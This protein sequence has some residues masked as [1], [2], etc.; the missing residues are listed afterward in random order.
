M[1]RFNVNQPTDLNSIEGALSAYSTPE[2]AVADFDANAPG[3]R[4]YLASQ[5]QRLTGDAFADPFADMAKSESSDMIKAAMG[6]ASVA[7]GSNT[8]MRLL[9][10]MTPPPVAVAPTAPG[11]TPGPALPLAL[12]NL[13]ASGNRDVARD[14]LL[15]MMQ[16]KGNQE[17]LASADMQIPAA[18]ASNYMDVLKQRA[19]LAGVSNDFSRINP[20]L[21]QSQEGGDPRFARLQGKD[22]KAIGATIHPVAYDPHFQELTR[23]DP[24]KA[25][26]LYHAVTNR[27]YGTD[28][29]AQVQLLV[30]QRDA[31]K[32]IIEDIKSLEADP[33][34][35]D[36]YKM[37]NVK[38]FDGTIKQQRVPVT[39]LDRAAIEA[40]GG[41][42]RIYGVD[43]PG[44]GGLK[45][46]PGMTNDE[47][48]EYR[49][50]TQQLM[51]EKGLT[52]DAASR[53]AHKMMDVKYNQSKVAT[54]QDDQRP[55]LIRTA[56]T[57]G[58]FAGQG[59]NATVIPLINNI[60]KGA[61]KTVYDLP[62]LLGMNLPQ[63]PQVPLLPIPTNAELSRRYQRS[64]PL[65]SVADIWGEGNKYWDERLPLR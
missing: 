15:K 40:E 60:L 42:K 11:A 7:T 44:Q 34:T 13:S 1:F 49:A 19:G 45:K 62:R 48:A 64:A 59:V 10:P 23:Q 30:E 18:N 8:G 4:D 28:H 63:A 27:D 20:D 65:P 17:R 58:Q 46:L 6:G 14:S 3:G 47:L 41:T 35:G 57:L 5:Y 54:P 52:V 61:N 50:T 37:I 36:L 21:L 53:L 31:R 56:D 38:D 9:S 39:P 25:N 29:D 26:A 22:G 55:G 24:A 43:L 2:A 16:M 12:P 33:V 51:K 32:K